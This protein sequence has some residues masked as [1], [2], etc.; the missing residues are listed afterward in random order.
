MS[1]LIF[2]LLLLFLNC[3][4]SNQY[5]LQDAVENWPEKTMYKSEKL[6]S[7]EEKEELMHIVERMTNSWKLEKA[8]METVI[9]SQKL[10]MESLQKQ[11]EEMKVQFGN[12]KN[13]VDE[14]ESKMDEMIKNQ[15]QEAANSLKSELRMECKAEVKKELDIALPTAVEQGLRDLPFEMVC[16]F[17]DR[18]DV[19]NSVVM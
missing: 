15:N 3:G 6:T 5:G 10:E 4:S 11:L 14:N 12:I 16:A 8:H 1:L 7:I 19:A 2:E 13:Q 17:Q 18:W 9:Q